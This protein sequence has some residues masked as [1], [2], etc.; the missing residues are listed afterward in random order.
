[1]L[2]SDP[3]LLY[4]DYSKVNTTVDFLKQ[5]QRGLG[6]TVKFMEDSDIFEAKNS[7]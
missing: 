1:V 2:N 3:T 7:S 6:I 5:K 4:R